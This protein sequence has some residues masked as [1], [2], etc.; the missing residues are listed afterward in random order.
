MRR[1]PIVGGVNFDVERC[2]QGSG[3]TWDGGTGAL[4]FEATIILVFVMCAGK[5]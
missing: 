3:M 4:E 5:G 2:R 1:V